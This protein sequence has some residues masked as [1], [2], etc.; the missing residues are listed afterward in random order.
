MMQTLLERG[1][2]TRRGIACAHREPA[3]RSQPWHSAG[4]LYQSERA[5]E[6]GIILPLYPQMDMEDQQAVAFE[7]KRALAQECVC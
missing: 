4:S 6:T 5:Q 2:A 7:I 3:Y 1:I